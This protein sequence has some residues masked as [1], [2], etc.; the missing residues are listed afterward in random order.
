LAA[1]AVIVASFSPLALGV[2]VVLSLPEALVNVRV[3]KKDYQL[4]TKLSSKYRLWD[5]F[6][7]Y[8]AGGGNNYEVR[9]LNLTGFFK[10]RIEKLLELTLP[11]REQIGFERTYSLT[12]AAIPRA[13]FFAGFNIYL[14]VLAL[15][16]V[17]TLGTAQMIFR[18]GSSIQNY[19]SSTI[20]SI[21]EIY[22]N[23]L[24]IRDLMWF[25]E[26]KP[27]Q[28]GGKIKADSSNK[29]EIEFRNVW[30]KYSHSPEWVLKGVSL[31]IGAGENVALVGENGAGKTTMIKLL[32]GFYQPQKGKIL[33]NGVPVQE[34]QPSSYRRL[35][36]VL[37]QE[38]EE[39]PFSA[40]ET[41]GYGDVRRMKDEEAVK[42]AAEA[43]KIDQVIEKWPRKYKQPVNRQLAHGI[44]PSK[45]QWQ[46]LALARAL[47]KQA[48]VLILDE[49][50]SNV[51]PKAEE[52]IFNDL[53]SL[54]AERTIILIS[55]RFATVRR[56][57][58]IF[59]VDEG[60]VKEAGSHE[61]LMKKDGVY[62]KLFR[63]QAKGYQ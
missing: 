60:E 38:F 58:K 53:I 8:L 15:A 45:G 16:Q 49:P 34:Y 10:R 39:Y 59:V 51:D 27:K 35:L 1:N 11:A 5:W 47:F 50:T 62:A 30:F 63:I 12:K 46:R 32:C 26:L 29:M 40:R 57:D 22:E 9:L 56:A 33:V 55:H 20:H 52:E 36:S 24:Y 25:L 14:F 44:E 41:I 21:M 31:E 7:K 43:T 48:P 42:Q 19:L 28:S 23:Q 2:M 4:R 6:N 37:F 18:A 61:E 13:L 54:N 3:T 17:I